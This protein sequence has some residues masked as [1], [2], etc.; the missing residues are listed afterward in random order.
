MC[1]SL[2][3]KEED[4]E[5]GL[6]QDEPRYQRPEGPA[7][8]VPG[9]NLRRDC[10][11]RDQDERTLAATLYHQQVRCGRYVYIVHDT[12]MLASSQPAELPWWFS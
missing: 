3:G 5:G 9:G 2:S 10:Q 7:T 1:M 12:G 6:H 11:Q 4:D 8:R